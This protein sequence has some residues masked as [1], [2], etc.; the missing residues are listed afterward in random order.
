M[1]EYTNANLESL[2][3]FPGMWGGPEATELQALQAMEFRD[4]IL[5]PNND[6]RDILYRYNDFL[7]GVFAK[8]YRNLPACQILQRQ[9]PEESEIDIITRVSELMSRFNQVL[10]DSDR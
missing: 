2:I 6:V 10:L 3:R 9:Y 8:S 4:N 7:R 5:H 1:V